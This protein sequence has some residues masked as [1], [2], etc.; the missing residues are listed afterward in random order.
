MR[1]PTPKERDPTAYDS[2]FV[3]IDQVSDVEPFPTTALAF[4][5]P[6][7]ILAGQVAEWEQVQRPSEGD[8]R[9][10]RG[11]YS[12]SVGL[13]GAGSVTERFPSPTKRLYERDWI[14]HSSSTFTNS[15]S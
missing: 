15:S 1:S 7:G 6:V 9:G 12:R 14:A 11:N 3:V 4:N 5:R 10:G 13:C 2:F 8:L